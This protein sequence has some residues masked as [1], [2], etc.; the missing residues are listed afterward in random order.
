NMVNFD[1]SRA[2]WADGWDNAPGP[3]P[4]VFT[5]PCLGCVSNLGRNTFTGPNFYNVDMSLFKNFKI[6]ERFGLQF[7]TESFNLLNNVNFKL[8][9]ANFAGQN[10]INSTKFGGASGAFDAR[11]LQFGLKL[12]F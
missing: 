11:Q 9:G 5:T 2:Q 12:T 1:P 7:R 10:R 8:P 3:T 6:T 4:P